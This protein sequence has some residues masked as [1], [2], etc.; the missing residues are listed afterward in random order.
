MLYSRCQDISLRAYVRH[1]SSLSAAA[2]LMISF[3]RTNQRA[4]QWRRAEQLAARWLAEG[5]DIWRVVLLFR[6]RGRDSAKQ[7]DRLDSL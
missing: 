5:L 3:H 4:F 6:Q 1:W 7:V 2:R